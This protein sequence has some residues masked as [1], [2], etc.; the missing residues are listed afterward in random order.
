VPRTTTPTE[1]EIQKSG[2]AILKALGWLVWRRNTGAMSGSHGGKKWFVKF[3]EKGMAD[4]WGF[5]PDGRHCEIEFKRP[6][7]RP[8][9]AQLAWLKLTNRF[10]VSFWV[11]NTSSL[12]AIAKAVAEG[13]R[14]RYG[15]NDN[16]EVV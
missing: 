8:T 3:G 14:I 7:K 6:G 2:I 13:R 11:C 15:D 10:G 16:Y 5:T 1:A 4:T 9:E 12:V